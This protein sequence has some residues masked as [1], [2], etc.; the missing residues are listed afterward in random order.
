VAKT[1]SK[2]ICEF[3]QSQA[4]APEYVAV[5]LEA[6]SQTFKDGG[7]VVNAVAG[8]ITDCGSDTPGTILGVP[9]QDANNS[10]AGAYSTTV[11]LANTTNVFAANVLESSLADHVLVAS[12]LFVTMAIQRD[13][14]NNRLFLNASTK[15]GT[16]C[17]V[18]TLG[19]AQN[20]D[21]GDTNG[22]VLFTFLPNFSQSL[23]TS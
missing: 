12:D 1:V 5:G 16:S 17:R 13:T 11:T 8:Y 2:D 22:R 14:S 10:T 7:T 18:F 9:A 4:N 3:V 21:I 6:A 19:V 15:A 20:T 23:G